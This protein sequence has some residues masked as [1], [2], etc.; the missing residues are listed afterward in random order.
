MAVLLIA[1]SIFCKLSDTE[2]LNFEKSAIK[3]PFCAPVYSF[4]ALIHLLVASPSK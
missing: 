1:D 4:A 3:Y 2:F